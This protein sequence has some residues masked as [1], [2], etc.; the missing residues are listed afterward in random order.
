MHFENL[1][2]SS[3]QVYRSRCVNKRWFQWAA[4][5]SIL[6][7]ALMFFFEAQLVIKCRSGEHVQTENRAS[8]KSYQKD[9]KDCSER[10]HLTQDP[11]INLDRLQERLDIKCETHIPTT[12]ELMQRPYSSWGVS[13]FM[14]YYNIVKYLKMRWQPS[15]IRILNVLDVGGSRFLK[16]IDVKLNI[17]RTTNPGI[18]IH[19]TGFPENQF[20]AVVADQVLEHLIYPPLAMIEINRILKPGGLAVLTTVAYNPLHEH[21]TFHDFWRFLPDG[22][23]VLSAPFDGG[24]KLCGSWGTQSFI[25]SRAAFGL[26]SAKEKRYFK[27][28]RMK[29]LTSNAINHPALVWIIVEK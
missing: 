5:T 14:A 8:C 9:T 2:Q 11:F 12:A 4:M 3:L 7:S 29:M 15:Q 24:I 25:V 20:D 27:E 17:T 22:L 23:R 10:K 13:R 16:S 28:Q 6:L 21:P 19:R 18:D 1:K 26:G